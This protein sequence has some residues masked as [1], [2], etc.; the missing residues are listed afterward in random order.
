[1]EH[2]FVG[3]WW[4]VGGRWDGG[5]PASWSVVSWWWLV[6]C[7]WSVVLQYAYNNVYPKHDQS[8]KNDV[9]LCFLKNL[10]SNC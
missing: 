7:R 2:L 9:N 8:Y 3:R 10:N 4:F 1:M 5:G 6:T